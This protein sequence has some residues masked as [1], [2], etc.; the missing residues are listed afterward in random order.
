MEETGLT[1][2]VCRYVWE[3]DRDETVPEGAIC[4]V[5]APWVSKG[6]GLVIDAQRPTTFRRADGSVGFFGFH[7]TRGRGNAACLIDA[8]AFDRLLHERG[9]AC[10][11]AFR[12]ER[13]LSLGIGGGRRRSFSGV[14]WFEA[15][16]F[17]SKT[18]RDDSG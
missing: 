8:E 9:L 13:L 1:A 6:T 10:L 12:G 3:R 15:G 18:W 4:L 17:K 16:D 14:A 11:W 2:T 7:E 5:P